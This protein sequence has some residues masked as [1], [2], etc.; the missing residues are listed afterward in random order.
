L[1]LRRVHY[2]A[3]AMQPPHRHEDGS[4][5]LVVA[6]QLEETSASTCH[7][8]SVGSV[9]IKPA[10]SLHADSYGPRGAC[11]IQIRTDAGPFSKYGLGSYR[12]FESTTLARAVLACLSDEHH[13]AESA[14]LGLWDVLASVF[15]KYPCEN[16]APPR[17]WFTRVLD[18]LERGVN[19]PVSVSGIAREVDVHP[20]HL[21]RVFRAH[22][23]RTIAKH[24]RE[25][26]VLAAW[27]AI[28]ADGPPLAVVAARFGFADQAHMTRAFG[29]ILGLSPG[30]LKRLGTRREAAGA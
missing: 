24:V 15:D 29:E 27:R 4:L 10:D 16:A 9:V 11:I 13:G 19:E 14:E 22:F 20:V 2:R 12:W 30:R 23:G 3:C 18:R 5:S 7:R 21:A 28:E 26:R 25:R 6:G 1:Q 8:A 17:A